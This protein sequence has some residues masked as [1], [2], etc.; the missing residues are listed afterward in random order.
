MDRTLLILGA[1]GHGKSVAEAALLA[2]VWQNI[3]FLDDAWPQVS[4]ALG[5]PVAGKVSATAEWQGRCQGAIAA[6]GNN[7]VREQW[8]GHIEGAGVE[9]VSVIHPRS[10]VSPSAVIGAGTAIMAG[11]VVGTVSSLGKGVIV[12]SNAT[13]DHDVVIGDYAHLGVG[14][15]LAGGVKVGCRAW[16]QAGSSCGYNVTVEPGV[17]FGP[18]TV[19]SAAAAK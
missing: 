14:V 8:I 2:G 13:V 12:N 6:V 17:M 3:V 19:L 7:A 4:E 10:W 18:G 16:L 15:Q 9:L 11:A 1:G 5:F